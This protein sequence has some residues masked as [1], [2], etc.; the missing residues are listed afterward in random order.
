MADGRIGIAVTI[1]RRMY[2]Y[3]VLGSECH[4]EEGYRSTLADVIF[5]SRR[6][7]RHAVL[8]VC[9]LDKIND[10]INDIAS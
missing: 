3:V 4:H 7:V 8:T 10:Q 1:Q 6:D 2:Y 5:S 9:N